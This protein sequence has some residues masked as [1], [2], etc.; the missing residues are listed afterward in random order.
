MT[1][2]ELTLEIEQYINLRG[3]TITEL[4]RQFINESIIEFSNLY[5]WRFIKIVDVITLDGSEEYDLDD[6]ILSSTFLRELKLFRTYASVENTADKSTNYRKLE[7]ENYVQ[8]ADKTYYYAIFG[9]KIYISGN[10]GDL[11]FM[12]ITPGDFTNYPLSDSSHEVPATRKYPDI[13]K[14]M[15]LVKLC[16]KIGETEMANLVQNDLNAKIIITKKGEKISE[17]SDK[18]HE[19]VRT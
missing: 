10:S 18:Y 5:N 12:Y 14:Y 17:H 16:K 6:T 2:A 7:Y 4:A 3:S 1:L 9:E 15:A 13:I 8:L 11:Q 19:I